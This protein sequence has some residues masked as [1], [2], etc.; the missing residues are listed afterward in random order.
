[1]IKRFYCTLCA[2]LL[3]ILCLPTLASC[4]AENIY[5]YGQYSINE[6]EY[7]YL[8]GTHK[9]TVLKNLGIGE[10][11][12]DYPVSE[13][14]S[15]TYGENIEKLYRDQFEQNV[16]S[17]LMAQMLFDE[18]GLSLSD[19]EKNSIKAVANAVLYAHVP[20]GSVR[21]F[22]SLVANYGFS[23]DSLCSVYEK[24]AKESAVVAYLLGENYSKVTD[25]QKDKYYN[26]NYIHF[27]TIVVNT[28]YQKNSDG[29]FSNLTKE[30][31]DTKKKLVEELKK[32]LCNEDKSYNY[33]LLPKFLKVD[34]M[35]KVTYEDIW[36]CELINDDKTYV[37]GMYMTK[38][39]A[40]QASYK[41]TLSQAMLTAI[42][43]V[44]T[45]EAK[46]YFDGEGSITLGDSTETI[47][48]GD[49][50]EY[51]TAF[52]KRLP[53]NEKAWQIKE[54]EIFFK[55]S[56]FVA[57]AARSVLLS[58]MRD[59]EKRSAHTLMVNTELYE[60][61]S[62]ATIPANRIDYDYFNPEEK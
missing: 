61:F 19:E 47:K 5:E 44:S 22:D 23:Y 24:Q 45:I 34:D 50:F 11:Y 57:G 62:L 37:G 25:T 18:F 4:G 53:L 29:S 41:N 31:S 1:M 38:P 9:R 17:L 6:E 13:T 33:T 12:L 7:A 36:N 32:F 14:D 59:Y 20:S 46:R 3:I 15:T 52:I 8:L 40:Y 56:S 39:T 26:D 58:T 2:F 49:Y 10:E 27:Q 54:N 21:S 42:G 30:E 55:D 28:L 35:S 51:G 16:H 48:K 43:D 60:E